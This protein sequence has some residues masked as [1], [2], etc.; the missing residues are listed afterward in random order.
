[1]KPIRLVFSGGGTRCLT[2]VQT[3]VEFESAGVLA[4]VKEYWGT[5]AGAFL[6]TLLAMTKSPLRVKDLMFK[7]DYTQFRNVDISNILTIT[8]TWG[9]DD[10]HSLVTEVERILESMEAG[11]SKQTLSDISGLNIVVSDLHSHETIVCNAK[12]YPELRVVDA[13]RASMSLPILFTPYKHTNGHLWVD[14]AIKANFPWHLLPNDKARESALGFAF[15]KSWQHGPKNFS[16][17]LFSMIHFDEPKKVEQLKATWR[18]NILWFP[19]PPF[20]SWFVR[21][22]EEDFILVTSIGSTIARDA[23]AKWSMQD[24]RLRTHGTPMQSAIPNTPGQVDPEDRTTGSS[25]IPKSFCPLRLLDSS[26][27]QLPSTEPSFRRW[28]V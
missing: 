20:P 16:E 2:F 11:A 19:S 5:S 10:G 25:D 9:L 3:L 21:F 7:T 13:I 1:M 8:N 26:Q 15:E 14:G 12:T 27:P 28:S 6:A 17:Y 22:K 23:L 18:R 24:S 4:N